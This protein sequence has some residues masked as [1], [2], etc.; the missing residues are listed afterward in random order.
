[1]R[2]RIAAILLTLTAALLWAGGTSADGP[3]ALEGRTASSLTVSWS[4]NGQTASAWDLAWRARGDDDAAAWRSVRKTTAQR[5]HTIEGLD[6]GVH[7]TIRVRALD[8]DDRSFASLQ[9]TFATSS[10]AAEGQ[11]LDPRLLRGL[12]ERLMLELTS[13]REL[14]TAGTLTEI[15][16]AIAGGKPPYSLQIESSPVAVDADSVRINCGALTEAEAADEEALLT[17][18]RV[19][20]VVTDARG[21]RREAALDVARA[22]ALPAPTRLSYGANVGYAYTTWDWVEGA[23]SQSPE[24]REYPDN[25]H[26]TTIRD[27]YLVRYRAAG[28]A[29]WQHATWATSSGP[30]VWETAGSGVHEMQVAAIR[31]SLESETPSVLG[32]S[33]TLRYAY[34]AAPANPTITTTAT[35]VTVSWDAQP[36]AGVGEIIL[37]CPNGSRTRIFREPIEPGRHS[38]TFSNVPPATSCEVVIDKS[39]PSSLARGW[40]TLTART[41]AP[42]AGWTANPTGP[43]NVAISTSGN[44]ITVTWASPYPGAP[45]RYDVVITEESTGA[46]VDIIWVTD[47]TRQWSTRGVFRPIRRG[48]TYRVRVTHEDLITASVYKTVTVPASTASG[49]EDAESTDPPVPPIGSFFP[50]WPLRLNTDHAYTD[51]PFE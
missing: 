39:T 31:H 45:N 27:Q 40:T 4:W 23:G 21:V 42:P 41:N 47:T 36:Y 7:Y 3:L 35:T 2:I 8:S 38:V 14:C 50:F 15:S 49:A 20:A 44:E 11:P 48:G 46:L 51:D 5:R 9:G 1:M 18:K 43:Q 6:A 33:E 12:A 16:W 19:T 13:S 37:A 10:A 34:G 22:R 32:W 24:R 17:A 28:E 26:S 25:P 29:E 30:N